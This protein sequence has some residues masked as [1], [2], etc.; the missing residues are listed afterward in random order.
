MKTL[1]SPEYNFQVFCYQVQDKDPLEIMEA[2][3]AEISLAR[4]IHRRKTKRS[5][6]RAG[7]K[8][9]AYCIQLQNL[10]STLMNGSIP[11]Q[12]PPVFREEIRP[13][14]VRILEKWSIGNLRQEFTSNNA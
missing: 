11:T 4:K 5:N 2:A 10:I 7:S 3:S 6:F 8:G 12:A 14:V 1:L 13:L 9:N